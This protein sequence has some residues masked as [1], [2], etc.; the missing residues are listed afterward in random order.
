MRAVGNSALQFA[1]IAPLKDEDGFD[2]WRIIEWD[3]ME[4]PLLEEARAALAAA[5]QNQKDKKDGS[6]A[7]AKDKKKQ[8]PGT[9]GGAGK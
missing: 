8:A 3:D 1:L 2:I 9:D 5:A 6:G 4:K 7:N